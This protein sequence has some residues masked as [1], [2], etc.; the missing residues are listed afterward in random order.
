[1]TDKSATGLVLLIGLLM[2]VGCTT[3]TTSDRDLVLIEYNRV[4]ELREAAEESRRGNRLLIV[5]V[6]RPEQFAQGHIPDAVNIPLAELSR[7]DPRL[8]RAD[9]IVVYGRD[10]ADSRGPAGAKQL[11][12]DGHGQVYDFRG[13][14]ELWQ[15]RGGEVVQ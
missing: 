9:H 7:N 15:E 11:I 4:V 1:M 6:R 5:D 3:R 2:F 13:G 8:T 14:L 10:W 12:Q